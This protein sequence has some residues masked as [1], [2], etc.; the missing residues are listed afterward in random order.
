MAKILFLEDE[1]IIREVITEYLKLAGHE[2]IE[3]ADGN[4]AIDL[5][6]RERFDLLILDINVPGKTGLEVLQEVRKSKQKDVAIIMLTAYDDL[7]YQVEAFN[8]YADDYITKPVTPIILIKRIEVILKRVSRPQP[9]QTDLYID[10]E[11]Y[12]VFYQGKNL[13]LTVS[14]FLLVE[15]LSQSPGKVFN[16]EQL[17]NYVFSENYICNDRV[18]DSHMKNLR[19]K[20][21]GNRID[22]V[23]G[24]GY[25]WRVEDESK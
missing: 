8:A 4:E 10:K 22:T 3:S 9:R 21:P 6:D 12:Q 15:I 20:L 11:G 24:I 16:R 1:Q 13:N 17:I 7:N 5:V 2:V 18:I 14:E 23:I 19:K 25:R